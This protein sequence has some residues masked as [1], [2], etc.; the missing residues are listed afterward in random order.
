MLWN[1][2]LGGSNGLKLI[3]Q[4]DVIKPGS[5]ITTF[6][7]WSYEPKLDS[8]PVKEPEGGNLPHEF[9]TIIKQQWILFLTN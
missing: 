8:V 7:H 5:L 4:Y 6:R 2:G 1:L 9:N 3:V